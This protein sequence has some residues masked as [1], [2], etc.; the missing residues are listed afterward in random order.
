M[1]KEQYQGRED[2]TFHLAFSSYLKRVS[3]ETVSLLSPL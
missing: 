1:E 3:V 2:N